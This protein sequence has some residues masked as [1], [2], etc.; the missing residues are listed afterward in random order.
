[1]PV[2][3]LHNVAAQQAHPADAPAVAIKIVGF[4]KIASTDLSMSLSQGRG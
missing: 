4:L 1:M 2:L 3:A